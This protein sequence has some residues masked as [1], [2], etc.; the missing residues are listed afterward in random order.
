[1]RVKRYML[2][3]ENCFVWFILYTGMLDCVMLQLMLVRLMRNLFN[4][5]SFNLLV[6]KPSGSVC[7]TLHLL[8]YYV[9]VL[10]LFG[11][12]DCWVIAKRIWSEHSRFL[13]FPLPMGFGKVV[14]LFTLLPFQSS[15]VSCHSNCCYWGT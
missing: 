4:I 10:A 6:L 7:W 11:L 1:M 14:L 3:F 8:F 2:L 15:L 9:L 13:Y 12:F 5:F